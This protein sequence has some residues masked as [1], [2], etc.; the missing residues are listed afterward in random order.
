ME[1]LPSIQGSSGGVTGGI[2]KCSSEMGGWA[3]QELVGIC[4]KGKEEQRCG[5]G[6]LVHVFHTT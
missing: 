3:W 2:I 5:R 6:N 4:S 1:R